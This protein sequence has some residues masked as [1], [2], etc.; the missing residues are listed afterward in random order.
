MY[1]SSLWCKIRNKSLK[2]ITVAYNG[3]LGIILNLPSSCSASFMFAT[4]YIK[5]FNERIRS[6]I[7][8][9][10][11]CFYQ[12]E[13]PRLSITS[14]QVYILEVLCSHSGDHN[15][16]YDICIVGLPYFNNY[17]NQLFNL[18]HDHLLI[19]CYVYVLPLIYYF[20]CTP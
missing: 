5:Y 8:S 6:S 10:L 7:F 17:F 11:C 20:T 16:T 9:L 15:C 19:Y 2:S 12:S 3:S 13:N 18:F 1:T 14:T 4:N